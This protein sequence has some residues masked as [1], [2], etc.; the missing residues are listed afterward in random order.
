MLDSRSP[1][2][3]VPNSKPGSQE[4]LEER[5][6]V[7]RSIGTL[8]KL[9]LLPSSLYLSGGKRDAWCCKA[10]LRQ[11]PPR[12]LVRSEP[13]TECAYQKSSC[14]WEGIHRCPSLQG[15]QVAPMGATDRPCPK[16]QASSTADIRR[17]A[18]ETP[19]RPGFELW[20]CPWR[21]HLL[22]RSIRLLEGS[23]PHPPRRPLLYKG[24]KVECT[25]VRSMVPGTEQA[26]H[27]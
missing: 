13:L 24:A 8:D 16:H 1:P 11:C 15:T 14:D 22:R 21:W 4:R 25:W 10:P 7:R 2:P 9:W 17:P 26:P 3:L 20:L 23:H 19:S 5:D 27:M 6:Q 12:A 18:L